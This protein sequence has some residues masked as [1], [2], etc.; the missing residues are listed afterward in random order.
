LFNFRSKNKK[1]TT[2]DFF[3]ILSSDTLIS[4]HHNDTN[5]G[6][7]LGTVAEKKKF[8]A[9]KPHFCLNFCTKSLYIGYACGK[10]L[11]LEIFGKGAVHKLRKFENF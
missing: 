10:M 9:M 6:Y 11:F 3:H 7:P 4:G 1:C 8:L 5:I 2:P